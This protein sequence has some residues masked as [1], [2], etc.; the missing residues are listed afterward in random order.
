[1]NNVTD[2]I[3]VMALQIFTDYTWYKVLCQPPLV[4]DTDNGERNKKKMEKKIKEE[5]KR[6]VGEEKL[7]F[8]EIFW[9]NEHLCCRR[10]CMPL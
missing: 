10:S 5:D 7:I 9:E 6:D 1:M 3:P 4:S 8:E 2:I